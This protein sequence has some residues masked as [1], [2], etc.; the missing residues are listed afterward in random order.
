M[1]L[2]AFEHLSPTTLAAAS[3]LLADPQR[4]ATI[5]GGG[6]DLF[7]KMKRRQATPAALVSLSEIAELHG[8]GIDDEGGCTIGASTTLAEVAAS[9]KVPPVLAVAAAAIA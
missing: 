6:T 5:V 7:P 8:I 9:T 4:A 2:P 3:E 1:R